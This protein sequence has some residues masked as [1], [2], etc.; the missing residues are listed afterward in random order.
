MYYQATGGM[1]ENH[2]VIEGSRK[3]RVTGC[4]L[5]KKVNRSELHPLKSLK[6]LKSLKLLKHMKLSLILP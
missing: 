4:E 3:V 6:S 2:E 5:T 1:R